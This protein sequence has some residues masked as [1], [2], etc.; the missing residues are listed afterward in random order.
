VSQPRSLTL[1]LEYIKAFSSKLHLLILMSTTIMD[2]KAGSNNNYIF[3]NVI[4]FHYFMTFL[5]LL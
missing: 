3:L 5:I 4:L 2:L 1:Y